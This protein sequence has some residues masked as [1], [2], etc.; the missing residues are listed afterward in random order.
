MCEYKVGQLP[1]KAGRWDAPIALRN[2][3]GAIKQKSELSPG[4]IWKYITKI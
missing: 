2:L 3:A 1:V 4:V